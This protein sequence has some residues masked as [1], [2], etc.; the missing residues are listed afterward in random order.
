MV[1]LITY[2]L[3]RPGKN[4]EDLYKAIKAIGTWWHYLDST[5]LVETSLTP[6]QVWERLAPVVDKTDRVLVVK[7]TSSNSGWL[8]QEAWDWLN[9]RSY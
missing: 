2:D 9:A 7:V 1:H 6:Q 3:N 5:W 8:T 4:Y